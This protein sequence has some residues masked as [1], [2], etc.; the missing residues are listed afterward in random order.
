M[1]TQFNI[2][3]LSTLLELTLDQGYAD[4]SEKL[5]RM[6]ADISMVVR[7]TTRRYMIDIYIENG[8]GR[9][10]L[11]ATPDSLFMSDGVSAREYII[12]RMK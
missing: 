6:G 10:L 9:E 8:M 1:N 4:I 3:E 12:E 2:N 5:I 7:P 11:E